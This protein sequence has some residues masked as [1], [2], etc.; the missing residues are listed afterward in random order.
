[1]HTVLLKWI[2]LISF[3]QKVLLHISAVSLRALLLSAASR[4]TSLKSN[5]FITVQGLRHS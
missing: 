2:S 3:E 5:L 4:E 1:M